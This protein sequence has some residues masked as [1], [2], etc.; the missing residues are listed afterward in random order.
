MDTSPHAPLADSLGFWLLR[1]ANALKLDYDGA[2]TAY[3]ITFN[4]FMVL[5]AVDR[6]S[7]QPTPSLIA[8]VLGIT[9]PVATRLT[10]KLA[11][12]D[13]LARRR[14]PRDQRQVDLGLT[15]QG[16]TTLK[17]AERWMN[18][19]DKQLE[20]HVEGARVGGP[21]GLKQDLAAVVRFCDRWDPEDI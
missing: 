14:N 4:Q 17:A 16:R 20:I 19:A 1:A 15:D 12:K 6:A 2:L 5:R 11:D 3:G 13:L 7:E 21:S 18:Q 9:P 8:Q 10:R